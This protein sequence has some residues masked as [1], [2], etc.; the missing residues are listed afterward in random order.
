MAILCMAAACGQRPA[1]TAPPADPVAAP[2]WLTQQ[3]GWGDAAAQSRWEACQ[4]QGAWGVT[5]R[6]SNRIVRQAVRAFDLER[7]VTPADIREARSR[8]TDLLI[9]RFGSP[10]KVCDRYV[11]RG[12]APLEERYADDAAGLLLG[13]VGFQDEQP[14]YRIPRGLLLSQASRGRVTARLLRD[15][16]LPTDVQF[17]RTKEGYV[18][19]LESTDIISR[20][21]I[22]LAL[23]VRLQEVNGG[24]RLSAKI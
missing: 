8:M 16:G 21:L 13:L 3:A 12:S 1:V 7:V 23:Q 4:R 15:L 20:R 18:L 24:Q 6:L 17:R 14:Y 2:G 10:E 5:R 9:W 19:P 11:R 22:D